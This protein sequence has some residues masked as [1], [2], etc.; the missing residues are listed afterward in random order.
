MARAILFDLDGTVW[1][2]RHWYAELLC[3]R[4]AGPV[5]EQLKRIEGGQPAASLLRK[6]G[7]STAQFNSAC[8]LSVPPLYEGMAGAMRRL[9]DAGTRL[10]A[11]TNLPKWLYAPMLSSYGEALPFEAVVGWSDTRRKPN[12]DP[13]ELAMKRLEIEPGP[14]HWYVGDT[15]SDAQATSAAGM[16]FAWATWGY[17]LTCPEGVE[18][19]LK[20]PGQLVELL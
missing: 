16:S 5:D 18:C 11:V 8:A 4:G 9:A 15:S 10:G 2:S 14:M 19:R 6:A 12:P 1:D 17:D 20:S 13:L 3:D 7:L